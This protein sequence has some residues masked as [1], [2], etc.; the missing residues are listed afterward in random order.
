M[1]CEVR[2][3]KCPFQIQCLFP[4]NADDK[5]PFTLYFYSSQGS[6]ERVLGCAYNGNHTCFHKNGFEITHKGFN[7]ATIT[8]PDTFA[9]SN[10]SFVCKKGYIDTFKN[11]S[12]HP[13][14]ICNT[15]SSTESGIGL[16]TTTKDV[17]PAVLA[18][19]IL[20][21]ITVIALII[22]IVCLLLRKYRPKSYGRSKKSPIYTVAT[23]V[24][25]SDEY[26]KVF[27][28]K[29][30]NHVNQ[31]TTDPASPSFNGGIVET[32]DLLHWDDELT[33]NA[34]T[35]NADQEHTS[36]DNENNGDSWWKL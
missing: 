15:I 27:L 18:G 17:S 34:P 36:T 13:S 14:E 24:I 21:L 6:Q 8:V 25:V 19:V 4:T 26:N 31:L 12:Y 10:G 35:A 29:E 3:E 33:I 1:S 7:D 16:E 32:K 2:N 30:N 20:G 9:T 11:C 5:R 22:V 23:P 28:W